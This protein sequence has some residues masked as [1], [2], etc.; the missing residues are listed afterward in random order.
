MQAVKYINA[1]YFQIIYYS[2][3]NTW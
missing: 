2:L 1:R 3:W